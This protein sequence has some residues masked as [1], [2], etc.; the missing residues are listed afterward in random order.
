M[1]ARATPAPQE[2]GTKTPLF[3]L[4]PF[5][6]RPESR[7]CG[8]VEGRRQVTAGNPPPPRTWEGEAPHRGVLGSKGSLGLR[9]EV[10]PPSGAP[11]IPSSKSAE[12]LPL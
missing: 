7:G 8:V 4:C 11:A 5:P 10:V 3:E 6:G 2:P 1:Q 12:C 9:R